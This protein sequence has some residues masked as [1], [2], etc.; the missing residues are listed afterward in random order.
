MPRSPNKS[1]TYG[2][3]AREQEQQGFIFTAA[4]LY[5]KAA[6]TSSTPDESATYWREW[7][8]LTRLDRKMANPSTGIGAR[9]DSDKSSRFVPAILRPRLLFAMLVLLEACTLS[10]TVPC[11]PTAISDTL[12][13]V[14]RLPVSHGP[15]ASPVLVV[16]LPAISNNHCSDK[17]ATRAVKDVPPTLSPHPLARN[18][19]RVHSLGSRRSYHAHVQ[20]ILASKKM[21]EHGSPNC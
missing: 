2:A 1:S 9:R 10:F 16:G 5:R 8:R 21:A 11:S 17:R 4:F 14:K 12:F 3:A 6:E 18:S 19:K 15:A 7:E 20:Q 13:Q